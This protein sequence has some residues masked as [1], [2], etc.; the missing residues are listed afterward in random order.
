MCLIHLYKNLVRSKLDYRAPIWK[1]NKSTLV[2]LNI[3]QN[4]SFRLFI[5]IP[6]LKLALGA[7]CTSLGLSDWEAEA[8][9]T[10]L[11]SRRLI[12]TSNFLTS[13]FQSPTFHSLT[14]SFH[15]LKV[16]PPLHLTM[17]S[18]IISICF[19]ESHSSYS[20][21][22]NKARYIVSAACSWDRRHERDV[23]FQRREG[24]RDMKNMRKKD[25]QTLSL[26]NCA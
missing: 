11:A 1:V 15:H 25:R 21:D 7:F 13:V 22:K 26:K 6:F 19:W 5:T 3:V 18:D 16:S 20:I 2:P 4:T 10:H 8:A 23:Y 14:Q 24:R 17:P 9:E 12:L